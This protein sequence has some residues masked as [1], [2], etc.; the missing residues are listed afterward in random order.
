MTDIK[1]EYNDY[2]EHEAYLLGKRRAE[3]K[4]QARKDQWY[5]AQSNRHCRQCICTSWLQLL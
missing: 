5:K 4:A 1:T 2:A 3:L